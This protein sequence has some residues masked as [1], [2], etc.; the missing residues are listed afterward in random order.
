MTSHPF[1][2]IF[3]P[4]C[5]LPI[6]LL[7]IL[8]LFPLMYDWTG[9]ILP[10][11]LS[12]LYFYSCSNYTSLLSFFQVCQLYMVICRLTDLTFSSQKK[13]RYIQAARTAVQRQVPIFLYSLITEPTVCRLLFQDVQITMVPIIS[14]KSLFLL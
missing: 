3:V 12:N 14:R 2:Y 10:L 4:N 1:L 11:L 5:S 7:R 8:L 13:L 9:G 6:C